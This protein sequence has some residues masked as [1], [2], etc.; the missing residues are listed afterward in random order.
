MLA[1]AFNVSDD[2]VATFWLGRWCV[3]Y[4]WGGAGTNKWFLRF[5][6]AKDGRGRALVLQTPSRAFGLGRYWK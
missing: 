6:D 3:A 5:L 4:A 2:K 1:P